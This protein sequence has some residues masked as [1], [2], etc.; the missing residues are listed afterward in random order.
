MLSNTHC[1]ALTNASVLMLSTL[2]FLALL[3]CRHRKAF[4]EAEAANELPIEWDRISA[5]Q[6]V[7]LCSIASSLLHADK[8]V[9][10]HTRALSS[11]KL[12]QSSRAKARQEKEEQASPAQAQRLFPRGDYIPRGLQGLSGT[13]TVFEKVLRRARH[14]PS[15]LHPVR[16]SDR[17]RQLPQLQLHGGHAHADACTLHARL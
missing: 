1:L 15:R 10:L 9:F 3:Y 12:R 13:P 4:L 6:N 8:P 2:S 7:T 16:L 5:F 11:K 17:L 14:V